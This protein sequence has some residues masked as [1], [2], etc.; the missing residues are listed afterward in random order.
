[1]GYITLTSGGL[2]KEQTSDPGL[3]GLN[4]SLTD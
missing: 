2:K 4:W 1:M 3:E